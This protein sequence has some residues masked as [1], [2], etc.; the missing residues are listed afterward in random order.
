MPSEIA[1]GVVLAW[2]AGFVHVLLSP[3]GGP[4]RTPPGSRCPLSPRLGW[5][6][7]VA[8]L[9]PVGWILFLRGRRHAAPPG[10]RPPAGPT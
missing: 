6:V 10:P 8:L 7:L 9:G 2:A 1:W 3:S 5:L 4:W